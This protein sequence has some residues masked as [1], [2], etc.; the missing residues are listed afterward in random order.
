MSVDDMPNPNIATY[1][2]ILSGLLARRELP[3][4]LRLIEDEILPLALE[5]DLKLDAQALQAITN[6][7]VQLGEVRKALTFIQ[8]FGKTAE[9]DDGANQHGR[10]VESTQQSS[11]S[12]FFDLSRYSSLQHSVPL[13]TILINVLLV[14][15]ARAGHFNSFW[16]LYSSMETMY[17]V[18]PDE[19]TLSILGKAA[20][21]AAARHD[22]RS[23]VPE[24][25]EDV[26]TP[27][28]Q[29]NSSKLMRED[30]QETDGSECENV[31]AEFYARPAEGLLWDGVQPHEYVR[32]VFW[33]VLEE[34]YPLITPRAKDHILS[35]TRKLLESFKWRLKSDRGHGD[36]TENE[37]DGLSP[38]QQWTHALCPTSSPSSRTALDFPHLM[39][40]SVNM[41]IFIALLGY[42]GGSKEIP[43]ALSYMRELS[44]KPARNTICL[45]MWSYEEGGAFTSQIRQFTKW[46]ERWIGQKG[47]PSDD[48]IGA[49]RRRQYGDS[50]SRRP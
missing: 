27:F 31:D 12:F 28:R 50:S 17:G 5:D 35:D 7:L 20:I 11:Q 9:Q 1:T 30:Y 43:L 26:Y 13:D 25:S 18:P 19:Y 39:P 41:H 21:S 24:Y 32:Q 34:N 38:S 48:E 47:M 10:S 44:I 40:T 23:R 14:A 46:L 2:V 3:A 4:A 8:Y 15:L 16:S 37:E 45:A 29:W 22:D 6:V 36:T 49:F 33:T 42:F